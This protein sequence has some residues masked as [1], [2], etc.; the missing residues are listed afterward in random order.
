MEAR[1]ILRLTMSGSVKMLSSSGGAEP[2]AE[3]ELDVSVVI[4]CLNE[5]KSVATV[6]RKALA[7]IAAAGLSGEVVVADNNSED[8]SRERAQEAGA[9]VVVEARR[10]YGSAYLAGLAAARGCHGWGLRPRP[11]PA[12]IGSG[13]QRPARRAGG[14]TRK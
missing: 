3:Q 1:T 9:R 11:A 13:L 10:G 14:G 6:V 8:A 4:P 5:E 7:G 12:A 2:A